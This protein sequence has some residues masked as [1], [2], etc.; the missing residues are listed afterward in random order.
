M[1]I[2]DLNIKTNQKGLVVIV[3]TLGLC[4]VIPKDGQK[5]S[6]NNYEKNYE[7]LERGHLVYEILFAGALSP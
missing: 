3:V 2:I 7:S 6:K 4:R 1:I 5:Y